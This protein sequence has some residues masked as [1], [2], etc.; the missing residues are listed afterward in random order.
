MAALTVNASLMAGPIADDLQSVWI[1]TF[2]RRAPRRYRSGMLYLAE[3]YLPAGRALASVAQ[4]AC[5]GAEQAADTGIDIAFVEAIFLP[6]DEECFILYRALR[7]ADVTAAGSL[8]G[9]A[10]DR[11]TS[12]IVSRAPGP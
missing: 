5:A 6:R 12:A 4:R 3:F 10:F 1:S 2:P 11:V 7:T 8:A 9:L